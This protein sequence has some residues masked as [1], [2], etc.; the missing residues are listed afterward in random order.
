EAIC[1]QSVCLVVTTEV[2]PLSDMLPV[3]GVAI[4]CV[5]AVHTIL[6]PS[7]CHDFSPTLPPII[8]ASSAWPS[9]APLLLFTV[10]LS[11]HPQPTIC[12]VGSPQVCQSP[13]VLWLEDPLYP[14]LSSECRTPLDL[15]LLSAM[16]HQSTS[17]AG[18]PCPSGSA[19]VANH[20]PPQDSTPPAVPRPSVH[21]ALSGTSFPPGQPWSSVAPARSPE[22]SA[23]PWPS[24]SSASPML[25]ASP[26][27]LW[28]PSNLLRRH[29]PPSTTDPPS[30]G[31]T[32][33]LLH[34]SHLL[35]P[36][37]SLAP[38]SVFA[39]LAPSVPVLAPPSV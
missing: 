3:M 35:P 15:S 13:S 38:P 33:G 10:S 39:T 36:V 31:S 14:P 29:C 21:L 25:T 34:G 7:A 12:A 11:A 23:P 32:V 4:W 8:T 26:S 22:P 30:V 37:F 16:A 20:P 24:G 19:L 2:N 1:E 6:E 18:L 17:S 28:A 5:W 9:S 27:P